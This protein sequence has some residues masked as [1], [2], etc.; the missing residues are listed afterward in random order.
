[1]LVVWGLNLALVMANMPDLDIESESVDAILAKLQKYQARNSKKRKPTAKCSRREAKLANCGKDLTCNKIRYGAGNDH[2]AETVI[3]CLY[4]TPSTES[5]MTKWPDEIFRKTRQN[6]QAT[7]A[8]V[9]NRTDSLDQKSPKPLVEEGFLTEISLLRSGA[10]APVE[11][12]FSMW[13]TMFNFSVPEGTKTISSSNF[14]VMAPFRSGT[15]LVFDQLVVTAGPLNRCRHLPSAFQL[16]LSTIVLA[17]ILAPIAIS[18]AMALDEANEPGPVTAATIIGR[19]RT[20]YRV[21]LIHHAGNHKFTYFGAK[22]YCLA[23]GMRVPAPD[24]LELNSILSALTPVNGDVWLGFHRSPADFNQWEDEITGSP[25]SYSNWA[26]GEPNNW[27]GR[28]ERHAKLRCDSAWNDVSPSEKYAT[29]CTRIIEVTSAREI[30]SISFKP[31]KWAD[32]VLQGECKPILPSKITQHFTGHEWLPYDPFAKP[33]CYNETLKIE[34]GRRI[35]HGVIANCVFYP[36]PM[37][38]DCVDWLSPTLESDLRLARSEALTRV[39]GGTSGGELR[40][41]RFSPAMKLILDKS[42]SLHNFTNE[43]LTMTKFVPCTNAH[44][45][46]FSRMREVMNATNPQVR[47]DELAVMSAIQMVNDCLNYPPTPLRKTVFRLYLED[48]A[49]WCSMQNSFQVLQRLLE[50]FMPSTVDPKY[51]NEFISRALSLIIYKLSGSRWKAE[52]SRLSTSKYHLNQSLNQLP[53]KFES[54]D[55]VENFSK[56]QLLSYFSRLQSIK[57]SQIEGFLLSI[58]VR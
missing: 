50:I 54:M 55:R 28:G 25:M 49:R 12:V 15:R 4:L 1:M 43:P 6:D 42:L 41:I 52:M 26:E 35:Q 24:S 11:R 29:I 18:V 31:E 5:I 21:L 53:I 44:H 38:Y 51:E 33:E 17:P 47:T 27:R 46:A 14:T 16:S 56:D 2:P 40:D 20:S 30:T 23:Y 10:E 57:G 7:V 37:S 34:F 36:R 8:P 45:Y 58:L 13:P 3:K 19:T 48:L 22:Q 32:M 39:A 9:T